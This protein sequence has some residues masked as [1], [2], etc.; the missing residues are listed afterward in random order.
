MST[1][2]IDS[3]ES[4]ATEV[5]IRES[6]EYTK[7]AYVKFTRYYIPEEVRG[8]SEMFLSPTQLDLLGR[9]LIRQASEIALAQADREHMKSISKYGKAEYHR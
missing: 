8:C 1:L 4:F 2:R 3:N 5:T 9:F 7:D 6:D